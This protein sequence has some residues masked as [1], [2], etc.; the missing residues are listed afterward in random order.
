MSAPNPK[1]AGSR[2][3]ECIPQ[4]GECPMGCAE[5]FYNG[6]RFYRTLDEPLL[7]TLE[8]ARGRIVRVNSGHDSNIGRGAV[9][10]AT[11]KYPHKFYNTSIAQ[12]NFEDAEHRQ[13]PVVFTCNGRSTQLVQ[14]P[15]NVMFVRVRANTWETTAQD[16]IVRYY[17]RQNVPVVITFM[18]YY[19]KSA[20]PEGVMARGDYVW[21]EHLLNEYWCP[22]A[23][24]KASVMARYQGGGVRMCGTLWSSLCVDCE[25]CIDLYWRCRRVMDATAVAKADRGGCPDCERVTA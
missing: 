20:I 25:N 5:C 19:D 17:Q 1:L 11:E 12:F 23:T 3:V 16:V 6:G 15:P 13:W 21:R 10:A 2:L 4:T 18:R 14:C 7:P 8:E 24:A 22:T 9:I